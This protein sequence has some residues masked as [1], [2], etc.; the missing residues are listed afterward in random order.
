MSNLSKCSPACNCIKCNPSEP[1]YAVEGLYKATEFRKKSWRV[2]MQDLTLEQARNLVSGGN[3]LC[4]ALRI[5]RVSY[6][7]VE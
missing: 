4:H 6:E 2:W 5:V 7:I 1:A 3:S